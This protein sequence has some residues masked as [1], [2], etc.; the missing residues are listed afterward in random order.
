[1]YYAGESSDCAL[2]ETV[3]RNLV[4]GDHQPQHIDPAI[5]ENRSIARLKLTNETPILDLRSPHFRH[6]SQD[7]AR[8]SEWQR[9]CVVPDGDYAQ[10]HA[11]AS[12]LLTAAPRAAGLCWASRQIAS[13]RAFVFYSSPLSPADFE[14]TETM[15]LDRPDGWRLVDQALSVIAVER[16]AAAA[17]VNELLD[18][19]PPED[20]DDDE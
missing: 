9:L 2:W 20:E 4:V 12:E 6:L 10:T 16:L 19:L 11:A 5:L 3:L 15:A 7:S 1:M 14:L 13:Q 17:L 8:H 18:E